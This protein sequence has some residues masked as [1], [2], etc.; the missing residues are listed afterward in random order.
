MQDQ[1]NLGAASSLPPQILHI[2][3]NH[4][5]VTRLATVKDSNPALATMIAEQM[6]DNA[7]VGAGL[8]DDVRGMVPRLNDILSKALDSDK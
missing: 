7:L 6:M 8:L 2:N 4:P 1:A 3:P 5:I